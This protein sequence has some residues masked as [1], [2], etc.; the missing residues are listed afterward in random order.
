GRAFA[1]EHAE[2]VFISV[3]TIPIAK[4]MVNKLRAEAEA[5]GRNPDEIKVLCLFTPIVGKTQEEA[6][7]KYLDYKKHASY[8]GALALF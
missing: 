3:P 4:T 7:E 5:I 1:A 8:E 6:E 2:C